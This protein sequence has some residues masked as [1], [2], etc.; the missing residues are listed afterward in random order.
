MQNARAERESSECSKNECERK[1]RPEVCE[2]RFSDLRSGNPQTGGCKFFVRTKSADPEK[3]SKRHKKVQNR[4]LFPRIRALLGVFGSSIRKRSFQNPIARSN[5][6]LDN[7]N[8]SSQELA[9]RKSCESASCTFQKMRKHFLC[10]LGSG[11]RRARATC[12][13]CSR[14]RRLRQRG[15][16]VQ[17]HPAAR[18]WLRQSRAR[19][20]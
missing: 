17:G 12:C 1:T 8:P 14:N 13:A 18:A 7:S 2:T 4:S 15:W 3:S 9:T 10:R 19:P 16:V 5:K 20:A 11:N 6:I